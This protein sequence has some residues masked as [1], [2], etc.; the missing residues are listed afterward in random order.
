[1]RIAVTSPGN[2]LAEQD[3]EGIERDLEK[4]DRRL[5]GNED[6]SAQ[7]RVGETQGPVHGYHV[8]VEVDY[9]RTHLRANA[10]DPDL[11][12]AVR[13]AR[14]ELLRQIND[15]SRRGHSWFAKRR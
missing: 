4:I 8:T 7:V 1:M 12:V 3:I 14:D 10:E 6:A 9:R 15:R 2:H 11:H 5:N 13:H